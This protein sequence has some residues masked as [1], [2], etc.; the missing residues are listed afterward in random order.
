MRAVPIDGE[1]R[2]AEVRRFAAAFG[3]SIG[4]GSS[5]EGRLALVATELATNLLKHAG[6][7]EILLSVVDDGDG[8]GVECLAL[9]RGPGIADISASMRDGHSTAG[10][11]GTGLGAILRQSQV[12]EI[13]SSPKHG[14]AVLARLYKGR[15]DPTVIRPLPAYG[16]VNLP[17]PGEEACGDAWSARRVGGLL[18]LIVVD[19]L[20]HGPLAA[21]AAHA[22]LRTFEAASPNPSADLMEKIHA[23]LRTTRGAAA[24]VAQLQNDP[25]AVV[26]IGVGNVAGAVVNGG[27]RAPYG[28]LQRHPWARAE[29]REAVHLCDRR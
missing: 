24:S 19:G 25:Q 29:N 6:G 13:Y 21:T 11:P 7:G 26:F 8:A 12:F 20:G 18:T 15:A 1:S 17:L 28:Q 4:F 16:A 9:D 2:V 14:A 22:A 23:A 5:D 10:S 3:K 27:R